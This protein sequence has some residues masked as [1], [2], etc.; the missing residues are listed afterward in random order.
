MNFTTVIETNVTDTD[1][2]TALYMYYQRRLPC[3]SAVLA[4]PGVLTYLGIKFVISVLGI[5]ANMFNIRVFRTMGLR[6]ST[7]TMTLCALSVSDLGGSIVTATAMILQILHNL[8]DHLADVL[9]EMYIDE[10]SLITIVNHVGE[11]FKTMSTMITTCLAVIRSMCV[12]KPFRFRRVFTPVRT[13]RLL[14][15]VCCIS[16]CY[17][18]TF[19]DMDFKIVSRKDNST[20][21]HLVKYSPAILEVIALING[22]MITAGCMVIATLS[23]IIIVYKMKQ[24]VFKPRKGGSTQAPL[25]TSSGT[26]TRPNS[27]NQAN[28]ENAPFTTR[29]SRQYSLIEALEELRST[30]PVVIPDVRMRRTESRV[31]QQ[32]IIV[33]V[34]FIVC[35]LPSAYIFSIRYI[36]VRSIVFDQASSSVCLILGVRQ[37]CEAVSAAVNIFVYYRFNSRYKSAF[38]RLFSA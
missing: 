11:I 36:D 20:Q 13:Q 19:I 30:G 31:I 14:C 15:G 35:K 3:H 26:E 34:I 10:V 16:L 8:K 25:S 33:I 9:Y 4:S 22:P 21:Y 7:V 28:P 38:R 27:G 23:V 5:V 18:V 2:L 6:D 12:I 24:S 29:I 17:G 37:L 1:N 32:V